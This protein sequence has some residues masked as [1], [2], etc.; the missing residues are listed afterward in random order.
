[1][2]MNEIEAILSINSFE[3]EQKVLIDDLITH[4]N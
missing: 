2:K 1:M 3:V 4:K